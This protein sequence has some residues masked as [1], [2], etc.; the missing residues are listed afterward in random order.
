[1]NVG[2]LE[3]ELQKVVNHLMLVQ[4]TKLRPLQDFVL[5]CFETGFFVLP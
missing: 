3:L 1:M 4:G 5:F 2:S